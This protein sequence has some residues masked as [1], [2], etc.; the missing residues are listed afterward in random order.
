M[1]LFAGISVWKY[2]VKAAHNDVGTAFF[3][4]FFFLG[5]AFTHGLE[6][7]KIVASPGSAELCGNNRKHAAGRAAVRTRRDSLTRTSAGR[8]SVSAASVSIAFHRPR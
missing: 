4:C 8:L 6:R 2:V 5:R 1:A 3:F 7:K